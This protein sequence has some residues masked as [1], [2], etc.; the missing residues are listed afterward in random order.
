MQDPDYSI[1]TTIH[2]GQLT[3]YLQFNE[4]LRTSHDPNHFKSIPIGF[5]E[6]RN[7]WNAGVSPGDDHRISTVFLDANPDH[8]T[9]N[10]SYHPVQ[11]RDFHI[12]PTQAG[13]TTTPQK[14]TLFHFTGQYQP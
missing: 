4:E 10:P 7:L 8:N 9:I 11:L 1:C 5:T 6:F 2:V 13:L 14:S 3:E 12:T